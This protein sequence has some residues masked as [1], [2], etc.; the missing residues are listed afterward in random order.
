M[1][2]TL[3]TDY[4]EMFGARAFPGAV[5]LFLI[6]VAAALGVARRK[7]GS[8]WLCVCAFGVFYPAVQMFCTAV[9]GGPGAWLWLQILVPTLI[10]AGLLW[11]ATRS[12]VPVVGCAAGWALTACLS[13][14]WWRD[15]AGLWMAVPWNA[16]VFVGLV[17][18]GVLARRAIRPKGH[19][20]KCGYDLRGTVGRVCPE[21]GT[22]GV[23]GAEKPAR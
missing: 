11:G 7:P 4:S 8:A 6:S 23:D 10:A 9:T 1:V 19:C 22:V 20:E 2:L 14:E 12:W 17:W 13:Y 21:C 15:N 18:W 5:L 16:P 3:A